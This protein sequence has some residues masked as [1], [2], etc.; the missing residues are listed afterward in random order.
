[1]TSG[2]A[3]RYRYNGKEL[4]DELGLGWYDYGFRWYDPA[5]GRFPSVDPVAEEL[6]HRSMFQ[7]AENDPISQIDLFGL[8]GSSP[9]DSTKLQPAPENDGAVDAGTT[10][11]VTITATRGNSSNSSRPNYYWWGST[12]VNRSTR[13]GFFNLYAGAQVLPESRWSENRLFGARTW[14]DP[15]SGYEFCVGRDG[16]IEICV[17]ASTLPI[18]PA[19]A[20][21]LKKI[22]PAW[23]KISI[24]MKH[25]LSGHVAGG[26]RVSSLK[27][28]FPEYMNANQIEKAVR[29]AYKNVFK[30][31]M[32][33]GDR[34]LVQ[35]R[36]ESGIVI[37]MWVNKAKKLI[38]TAYPK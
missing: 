19:G 34:V 11:E 9:G 21:T 26:S 2:V 3:N 20:S 23:R 17:I 10:D 33:Q 7:Y 38:E 37:E 6:P 13:A 16:R 31:I 5:I 8:M 18:G 22:L 12:N 15:I 14:Q 25:I 29:H 32:T 28:L 24:D 4:N 30:K 27:S 1:M 36:T 35:G